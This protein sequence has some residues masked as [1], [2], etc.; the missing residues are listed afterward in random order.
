MRVG[1]NI[2]NELMERFQP[3]KGTFNLSRICREAI[4]SYIEGYEKATNQAESD[5]MQAIAGKLASEY[6][7]KTILDWESI[8]RND[9]KILAQLATLDDL[10]GFFYNLKVH[11]KLG[12]PH[13]PGPF[14]F[15][16]IIPEAPE[17]ESHIQE[18]EKWFER[19]IELDES[20]SP[21]IEARKDYTRGW[22]SYLT[23]VWQM[24]KD[25]IA[26]ERAILQKKS[27]E[28]GEKD[29]RE[30]FKQGKAKAEFLAKNK[31]RMS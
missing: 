26:A 25:Q 20:V 16:R 7:M 28:V 30:G 4:M 23:V 2:S 18:R 8:G 10:E 21:Y 13:E 14:L 24:V 12:N 3:L 5:G 27:N 1:I 11:K 31:A 22:L 15:P 9:A 6:L 17:F 29:L 19:Q